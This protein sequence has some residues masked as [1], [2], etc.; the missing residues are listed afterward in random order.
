MAAKLT[1][2]G[3]AIKIL[4]AFAEEPYNY[5]AAELSKELKINRTT[6]HR[7]LS[8]LEEEGFIIQRNIDKKYTIGPN[9]FHIGAKYLYRSS[10]F[11]EIKTI[12]EKLALE[13]KQNVGFTILEKNKIINLYE[14]E[15][16][17]PAKITYAQGTYFPINAGAYGKTIM[18]FYKPLD[19][20]EKIVRNTKLEKRAK[21]TITDPDELLKEYKKI[22]H[23]GYAVSDEE[24][25]PGA[26][27]VGVPVFDKEGNIY[28]CVAVA[29]VKATLE[30]DAVN[31]FVK[32][33]KKGAKEISNYIL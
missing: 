29:A 1:A 14:S 22:R 15:V 33:M 9:L 31:K 32:A 23:Q 24:N 30:D 17:M 6:V 28:G 8:E 19:E 26:L 10:N 27:G 11:E 7:I 2:V 5:S 4:Q 16:S 12:I 13:T 21:N 20:L 25:M 3:K 18:A